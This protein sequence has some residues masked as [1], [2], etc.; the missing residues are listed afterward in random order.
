MTSDPMVNAV[1]RPRRARGPVVV[2]VVL[3]VL[4]VLGVLGLGLGA[5]PGP[6]R[7]VG[8]VDQ[9]APELRGATLAGEQFDLADWRGQVVLV[10]IWASWCAPCRE[11]MPLLADLHRLHAADGLRV[12]GI[13]TNDDADAA[14]RFVTE[15]GA[16]FPHVAD[17][18]AR[19]AIGWGTSG[20]PETYVV[21]RDGSVVA[22]R[23]GEVTREWVVRTVAPLLAAP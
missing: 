17:P 3:L 1:E 2:L 19:W 8:L 12:V 21:D 15:T 9:P 16:D 4:G 20:V 11:E 10:N 23:F 18:D 14:R 5:P 6:P 22:K 7:P 13:N